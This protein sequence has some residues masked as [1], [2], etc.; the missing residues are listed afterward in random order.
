[1]QTIDRTP[2]S[3][4]APATPPQRRVGRGPV[5]LVA[6][7]IGTGV[8]V[9]V[10]LVAAVLITRPAAIYPAGSPEAAFQAYL[11]A[12]RSGD[13]DGAYAA[14]SGDVRA[15]LSPDEYES[16]AADQRRWG[17]QDDPRIVLDRTDRTAPDRV[18]LQMTIEHFTPG[19]LGSSRWTE[20]LSVRMV[21]EA[22]TWRIDDALLGTGPAPYMGP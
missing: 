8:I 13:L 17:A 22:A 2:A 12:Y 1:M 21:L 10:A 7:A 20:P 5:G 11:A 19:V 6:I 4:P 16:L 18:T 14:F 9:L 15:R 3:G